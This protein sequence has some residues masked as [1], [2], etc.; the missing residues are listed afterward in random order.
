[1][2]LADE[3]QFEIAAGSVAG[4]AH[5]RSGRA[6]QDAF[7]SASRG[8]CLVAVVADGCGSGARSEVGAELGARV[9]V[10]EAMK[11]LEGGGAADAPE[12]WER[13]RERALDV[14]GGAARALG[15]DLPAVVSELFLFTVLGVAISRDRAA[16][17]GIGDGIAA[18]AG[19]GGDARPPETLRIGPFPGNAPPYLGYGLLGDGPR[20]V[21]HRAMPAEEI[22]AVLV[23]TDGAADLEGL[24][25]RKLPGS[26][27]GER[28]GPLSQ[29]W[30]Q[31]RYFQNRD[32]VR[33]RLALIGRDASRPAWNERRIEREPGLLDDDTT[34]IVVRRRRR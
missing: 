15:G 21:L 23:G 26:P 16:I 4:R 14:L 3:D 20:F 2:S 28:V 1:M 24:A 10:A 17:F 31:D 30:S 7:A 6:S 11:R 32:A 18:V 33:R 22:E 34:V 5:V 27:S 25:E 8:G 13:V 29:L 19:R 9:V 12:L